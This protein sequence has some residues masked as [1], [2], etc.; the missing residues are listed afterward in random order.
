MVE[1]SLILIVIDNLQLRTAAATLLDQAGYRTCQAASGLEGLELARKKIP[2]LILLD[3]NLSDVSGVD[4]CRQIRNDPA[5]VGSII[6][7]FSEEKIDPVK[8]FDGLEDCSD[9]FIVSPVSDAELIM[10]VQTMLRIQ[11]HKAAHRESELRLREVL[12]NSL[13][14]SY[15]R[16]LKTNDYDYLSPVFTRLSGYTLLEMKTMPLEDALTLIHPDDQLEVDR[17]LAESLTGT[18]HTP[19]QVEYRFKHKIGRAHV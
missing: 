14:A 18:A 11:K 13:D 17:V 6:I 7:L 4:V 8:D 10:Q 15:K 9:S 2:D 19:Y 12:E 5:L 16:N 3:I 1:K